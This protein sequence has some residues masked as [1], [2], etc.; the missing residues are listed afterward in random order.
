QGNT[1]YSNQ[2]VL[3]RTPEHREVAML[4]NVAHYSHEE[5]IRKMA[6]A[7]EKLLKSDEHAC[8]ERIKCIKKESELRRKIYEDRAAKKL[9]KHWLLQIV[10]MSGMR[11]CKRRREEERDEER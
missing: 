11:K 5:E 10:I 3:Q 6:D 8:R 2:N 9:S 1:R 7:A 4:G